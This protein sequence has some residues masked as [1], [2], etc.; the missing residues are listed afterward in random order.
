MTKTIKLLILGSVVLNILLIGVI[1]G[2]VSYRLGWKESGRRHVPELA[3]KLPADK[4]ELFLQTMKGVHLENRN[5]LRQIRDTRERALSVLTA[6]EFDEA[7]Y[8]NEVVKLHWLRGLMMQ[9]LAGAAKELAKQFNQEER[10]ALAEH[11]RRPP[12]PPLGARS[13][14]DGGPPPY[15]EGPPRD[16]RP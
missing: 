7:A 13:M 8:Q 10:K 11:L 15:H 2:H 4:E 6:P 3:V 14:H 16:R 12:R 5:V 9:R 1:I